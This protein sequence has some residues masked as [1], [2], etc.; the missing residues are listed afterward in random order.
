LHFQGHYQIIAVNQICLAFCMEKKRECHGRLRHELDFVCDQSG[1]I[2]AVL[3]FVSNR[4]NEVA[5]TVS[6]SCSDIKAPQMN[7]DPEPFQ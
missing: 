5:Q 3:F 7:G 6:R 2:I 1:S 4:P